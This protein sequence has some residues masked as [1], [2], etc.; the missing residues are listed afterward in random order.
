MTIQPTEVLDVELTHTAD[1]ESALTAF[2]KAAATEPG[3]V[4]ASLGGGRHA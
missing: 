4:V 1:F 3:V 2:A